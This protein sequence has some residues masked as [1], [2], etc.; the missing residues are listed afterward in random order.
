[1]LG[2][3][4]SYIVFVKNLIPHIL[5]VLIK[6]EDKIPTIFGDGQWDGQVFWATIY[7][8]LVLAPLSIPRTIGVLRFNSLFG[9]LCSFYLVLTLLF[10]FF[11]DRDLVPSIKDSFKQAVYV[12]I[13]FKGLVN[14]VPFI[15]FAFMYQGNIPSVYREL[16]NRNYQRMEKVIIRGSGSVVV[17]YILAGIFGYLGL[18]GN[19]EFLAT[20]ISKK[21]VL[22]IDYPNWAMKLAVI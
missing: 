7:T 22:E 17:V 20:L 19:P 10:M 11:V 21:N 6:D 1:M 2:F 5:K 16:H 18:V 14:T 3:V 8:F 12:N 13:T 9:V 15:V 4:V